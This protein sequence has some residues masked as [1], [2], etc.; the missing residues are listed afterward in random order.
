MPVIIDRFQVMTRLEVVVNF[1]FAPDALQQL[2]P[3]PVI[4]QTHHTEP[5][6]E[7]STIEFTLWL[8][9]LPIHWRARHV[10]VVRENGF[11]DVQEVGPF[12]YWEHTQAWR[13]DGPDSTEVVEIIRYRHHQGLKGLFTKVLLNPV[14]TR[15]MFA[16]H[17]R[18]ICNTCHSLAASLQPI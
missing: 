1:H 13:A 4:V 12:E 15:W 8:G 11:S 3:P 10:R 18:I 9:P 14:T 2:T 5:L 16:F 17:R 6:A 7:N